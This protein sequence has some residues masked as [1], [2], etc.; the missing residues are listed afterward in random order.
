MRST[1]ARNLSQP[2]SL[3]VVS[4]LTVSI[5]ETPA[6]AACS[7]LSAM[8]ESWAAEPVKEIFATPF[9][10]VSCTGVSV[11]S[12]ATQTEKPPGAVSAV[13]SAVTHFFAIVSEMTDGKAHTGKIPRNNIT[14]TATASRHRAANRYVFKK[15]HL[16]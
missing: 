15:L 5:C 10:N 12:Q 14:D 13:S 6:Q 1:P 3:M 8:L 7:I 9:R 4:G 11:V 16:G 2:V